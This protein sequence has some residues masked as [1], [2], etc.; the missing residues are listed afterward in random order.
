MTVNPSASAFPVIDDLI[1]SGFKKAGMIPIEA[2]IGF[3]GSWAGK[4]AYGRKILNRIVENLAN[5][6]FLPQFVAIEIIQLTAGVSQYLL[7]PDILNIVDT[8]SNI[9][10][11]NGAETV[12]T[13]SETPVAPMSRYQWNLLST[14]NSTGTP[15]RYFLDRNGPVQLTMYLWPIPVENS[16]LRVMAHRIPADNSVGSDTV[17]LKRHWNGYLVASLA[18]E[19]ATDAKLP[20]DERALLKQDREDLLQKIKCYETENEPPDVRFDHPTGW[21]DMGSWR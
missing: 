5:D 3:D 9:P 4:A 1:L 13:V 17:D 18:Y 16:S 21:S 15:T 11:S 20:L 8:A 6:G 14:K 12:Q 2:D 19:I 7:D 10:A